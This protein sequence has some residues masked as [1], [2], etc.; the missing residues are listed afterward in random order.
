MSERQDQ[1]VGMERRLDFIR[2]TDENYEAFPKIRAVLAEYA[3]DAL[4]D[5][6]RHIAE[7]PEIA[8]FFAS[9]KHADHARDK[10]L[11]HWRELFA[12]RIDAQYFVRAERIGQVHATI[13]L[14][15]T[16][17]IGGYAAVL[18]RVIERV[19]TQGL[20]TRLNGRALSDMLGTLVKTA[21]LD[22]DVALS[23]YFRVESERRAAVVDKLGTALHRL[24]SGDFTVRLEDLPEDYRKLADD[25]ETMRAQ[26]AETIGRVARSSDSIS[27]GSAEISQASDDLAQ[28]TEQQAASLEETADAMKEI[29]D[30]VRTTAS[31]AAS[32]ND[33][34][35]KAHLEASQGAEIVQEAVMA[36]GD[37]ESSARQIAQIVD[38]IDGISFQTNL[39]ALN[40]G[41]EA[42]R[43]GDSGRGF[44]VVANEV[45]ALAQRSADAAQNIKGLIETSSRQVERG[46]DLVGRTGRALE[47]IAGRVGE[48]KVQAGEISEAAEVQ[49]GRLG[50]VSGA[51][52]N[53]DRMTQQNAAMVEQSS[54][55]ARTLAHEAH[56]LVSAVASFRLTA[57]TTQ[58]RP[59]TVT[60]VR[61]L[62][63]R[64]VP[65]PAEVAPMARA[66]GDDW[67]QF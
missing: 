54:A 56:E 18:E 59:V 66:V 12:R 21:L 65:A 64:T 42:A 17:Y 38:L 5:L 46:V 49:A 57:G 7:T 34:V 9:K 4:D 30:A 3:S 14:E 36:M 25:F 53:M 67:T 20:L 19:L 52:S 40:A 62:R 31:G 24:A 26:M 10:Q 39:L 37:I 2:L 28:R 16:W 33:T 61:P 11:E 55:A 50:L 41:V 51:V 1:G 8:S 58:Q 23:S 48:I 22:M 32:V 29:T 6:Y 15:P 13:G 47:R 45:R 35:G 27:I 43:A 60:N 44:A 63:V